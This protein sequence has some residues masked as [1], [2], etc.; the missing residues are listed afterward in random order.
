MLQ[1]RGLRWSVFDASDS[2]FVY[3][4]SGINLFDSFKHEI[5]MHRIQRVPPTESKGRRHTSTV[6]VVVLKCDEEQTDYDKKDF[7]VE[8]YCGTGPGGQH[9]N[10]NM[11]AVRVTHIPT[12]ISA[13]SDTRSQYNNKKLAMQVVL[14]RLKDRE[15][16]ESI[17]RQ[18]QERLEQVGYTSRSG[19]KVR[20]YDFIRGVA[21][22]ERTKKK[23]RIKDVMAGKL[24]FIYG[25]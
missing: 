13:C 1:G 7:K 16:S 24:D 3:I 21:K 12:K 20:T 5:G 25:E 4:I 8:C 15:K 23:Q 2:Y 18:K 10:K 22:D 14:A 11:T 6:G 17:N 9:R 19:E